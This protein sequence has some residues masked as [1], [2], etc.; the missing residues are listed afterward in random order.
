MKAPYAYMCAFFVFKQFSDNG[1]L[2]VARH[3]QKTIQRLI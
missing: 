1:E 3:Y 2:L